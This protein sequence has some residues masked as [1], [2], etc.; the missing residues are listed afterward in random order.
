MR[1]LEA[2]PPRRVFAPALMA[3]QIALVTGGGTGLGRAI[4]QGLAEAGADL[5]LAAR[6]IEPLEQAA[7]RSARRRAVASR[8]PPATSANANRSK[9]WR[10]ARA[11]CLAARS[12]CW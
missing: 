9:R 10:C 3:G 12:T 4:A 7:R 1:N 5:L 11:S 6:R 8:S 2:P